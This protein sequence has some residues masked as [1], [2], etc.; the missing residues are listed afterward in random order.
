MTTVAYKRASSPVTKTSGVKSVRTYK[1][2]ALTIIIPRPNVMI[3]MGERTSF[4]RG[5]KKKTIALKRRTI[6]TYDSNERAT[7]K[8]ATT[9]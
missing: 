7:E 1:T 5:R 3:M 8:P 4:I 6:R 2:I 9:Y